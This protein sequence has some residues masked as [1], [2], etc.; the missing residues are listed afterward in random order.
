M[1]SSS[2]TSTSGVSASGF[3]LSLLRCAAGTDVGMRREE[4]QDSFGVI[5]RENFHAYLVADGMG[6]AQGGAI[7]SRMAISLATEALHQ[8]STRVSPSL[9]T[10]IVENINRRIF[11]KGSTEPAYAGMGTT[12][13]GLIFTPDSLFGINVGDSRCY[14]IRGDSVTQ[15]SEDHTLVRE[16]VQ[17]GAIAPED[18]HHHPVSHM[19]TRSLGPVGEVQVACNLVPEPPQVG[20]IYVLC[21]DGLYNHVPEED[22]MAV[23]KQNPLDDANQILINLANQRGGSDNITAL[24]IAVGE[25]PIRGRKS[26]VPPS[27]ITSDIHE[28]PEQLISPSQVTT[29]EPPVVP[30]PVKEPMDAIAERK[31]LRQRQRVS[32]R[33]PRPIP[34]ALLLSFTLVCGLVLGNLARKFSLQDWRWWNWQRDSQ[35]IQEEDSPRQAD[36][37]QEPNPLAVL[38]R[39]IRGDKNESSPLSSSINEVRRSPAQI[40][41]VIQ[42]L[43]GQIQTLGQS[44][45][46]SDQS[47]LVRAREELTRLERG[48]QGIESNLDVASRSVTLWLG[49]QVAFEGQ[50]VSVD[51]VSEMARIGTYSQV[52]KEK[53]DR[54][55]ALSYRYRQKADDVELH[56]ED[57]GLQADL[58][59]LDSQRETLKRELADDMLQAI[60]QNL[61]KSFKDYENL[62]VQRDLLWAD[63]QA[64]KRQLE[65]QEIIANG[66]PELRSELRRNLQDKLV[67]E[68]KALAN[69]RNTTRGPR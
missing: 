15:I 36:Y 12:L 24:V 63:L 44:S 45:P 68:Q 5:R 46:P 37:A 29:N 22:I 39:Q 41:A 48:Y 40:E 67:A 7:A 19:L 31:A 47:E 64:A 27:A 51:S 38:A 42:R 16:L 25:K 35:E 66:K 55:T 13:V 58:S 9:V 2:T 65:I 57:T 23:V 60:K 11:E 4:N 3:D 28:P 56:P 10:S 17:S 61:A 26:T 1:S 62:K 20:D 50:E 49:R 21:S 30:P 33:G 43:Q 32:L 69:A 8:P 18:A 54:L 34:T 59:A 6:G 14:R 52:V 53:V